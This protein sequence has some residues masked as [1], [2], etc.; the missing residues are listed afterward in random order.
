[1]NWV[2]RGVLLSVPLAITICG[3]VVYRVYVAEATVT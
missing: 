1:M 2:D 3:I